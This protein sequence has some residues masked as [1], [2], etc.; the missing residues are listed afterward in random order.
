[1][2]PTIPYIGTWGVVIGNATGAGAWETLTWM[3]AN[4]QQYFLFKLHDSTVFM[5]KQNLHSQ[6][7]SFHSE[8]RKTDITDSGTNPTAFGVLNPFVLYANI[9]NQTEEHNGSGSLTI[10][11][12][13]MGA[14]ARCVW[15][16]CPVPFT[17]LDC[18]WEP[19]DDFFS[20]WVHCTSGLE[21][22]LFFMSNC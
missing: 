2:T 11:C 12:I 9:L 6:Y 3:N 16:Q 17:A 4:R 21:T 7:K 20:K 10:C 14:G 19:P 18:Q 15:L 1:M 5:Y 8:E 13:G 22:I